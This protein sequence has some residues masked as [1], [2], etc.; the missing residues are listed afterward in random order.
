MRLRIRATPEC[1]ARRRSPPRRADA[2]RALRVRVHS[3]A[4]P[5]FHLRAGSAEVLSHASGRRRRREAS[6]GAMPG[7][8]Q[9]ARMFARRGKHRIDHI[10]TTAHQERHPGELAFL[11]NPMWIQRT[12]RR[13]S[14]SHQLRF[15]SFCAGDHTSLESLDP[16]AHVPAQTVDHICGNRAVVCRAESVDS[17]NGRRPQARKRRLQ[18]SADRL[19]GQ[20]P[21]THAGRPD[22]L[23]RR[24][25]YLAFSEGGARSASST[26]AARRAAAAARALRP[27]R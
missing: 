23:P 21:S 9:S 20:R 8:R 1:R 4:S 13:R 19:S 11:T 12:A 24:R 15:S 7:H 16:M 10:R 17:L 22:R 25:G 3:Q 2:E 5:V 18:V 26:S 6:V 14:L 27:R